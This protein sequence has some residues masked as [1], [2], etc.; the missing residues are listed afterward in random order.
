MAN[1]FLKASVQRPSD[2]AMVPPLG[3]GLAQGTI[4]LKKMYPLWQE[5]VINGNTKLQFAEW[6]KEQGSQNPVMPK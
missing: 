1:A 3:N 5:E 6:L 4:D 2:N